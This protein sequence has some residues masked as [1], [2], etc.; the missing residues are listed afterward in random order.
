LSQ[1]TNI[2]FPQ[3]PFLD[4]NTQKPSLPWL[5]W[6]QNPNFASVSAGNPIQSTSGGTGNASIPNNGQVLVGLDSAYVPSNLS[7]GKGISVTNTS[8]T[9][10]T[11][12]NTGIQS[13]SA[14]ATGFTP[15]SAT[16]GAV[17]LDGVLN[18]AHGGTNLTT[19]TSNGIIYA[20]NSS[21]IAQIVAPVAT[22]SYLKWT[23][24]T[25]TWSTL[26]AGVTSFSA[27]TTGLTP[28]SPTTGP[29]VLA[30]TLIV[31]NGGTG[32]TTASGAR[33]NLGL[34]SGLSVTITTAALTLAGTTGSMTFTNGI[35][36]A[37]TAAT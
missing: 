25:F 16:S 28:S 1:N 31:A 20:K 36:T 8:A 23:G 18:V 22:N 30:G 32:S 29:V 21:T 12:T 5:L 6:L 9:G 24:N 7:G 34:G 26:S 10:I 19:Y 3:A 2:S 33:T 17:T 27:G 14:G 15:I 11:I 35:L 37:Q 4:P 13:F